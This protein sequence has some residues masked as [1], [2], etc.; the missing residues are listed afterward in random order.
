MCL[1]LV[2]SLVFSINTINIQVQAV[3]KDII[4]LKPDKVYNQFDLDGDGEQD[5]L[6]FKEHINPEWGTEMCDSFYVY[7]NNEEILHIGN[8]DYYKDTCSLSLFRFKNRYF[9]YVYLIGDD[10][11]GPCDIYVY[12]NGLFRKVFDISSY[13]YK[14]GFHKGSKVKAVDKNKVTLQFECMS[15]A[16][17]SVNM[18]GDFT[19]KNGKMSPVSKI[20]KVVNYYNWDEY[21]KHPGLYKK[22]RQPY[23]TVE[24]KIQLYKSYNKKSKNGVVNK[25]E[26]VKILKC[27]IDH[28]KAVYQLKTKKNKVGWFSISDES[29]MNGKY[30]KEI[31]YSG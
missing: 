13:M 20:I 17:A 2:L 16:V 11:S 23:L 26:K 25:G 27:Y 3:N 21:D 1:A 14:V 10:G 31:I 22:D 24:R 8:I 30:F 4:S 18:I 12:E 7:V 29:A 15:T 9:L 28:N 19:Y 6:S 5:S